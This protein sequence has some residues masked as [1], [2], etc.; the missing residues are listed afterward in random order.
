MKICPKCGLRYP[1]ESVFCFIDGATIESLGDET[2]GSTVAGL[3]RI[4]QAIGSSGWATVYRARHRLTTEP[5]IV[6]LL[7]GQVGPAMRQELAAAAAAARRF[8]HPGV[9]LL[10]SGG[11]ADGGRAYFARTCF[12]GAPLSE[13]LAR[14]VGTVEQVLGIGAQ[15]LGALAH[16]HDFGGSHGD[17][18]PSNVLLGQGGRILLVDVG[19]G[20]ARHRDPW[21]EAGEALFAQRYLA[22]EVSL[23]Q[24]SSASADLY[25]CGVVLF[26]LLAR[27]P[28]VEADN[29]R[30]LRDKQ[31]HWDP[32]QLSGMLPELP[33]PLAACLGRLLD[34][35]P[36]GRPPSAHHALEEL[37]GA[38][39]EQGL[40]LP[41]LPAD[42]PAEPPLR[43]PKLDGTFARWE[44]YRAVFAR[45]LALAF[46]SGPPPQAREAMERIDGKLAA[47]Q[48]VGKKALYYYGTLGDAFVRA[49]QGRASLGGQMAELNAQAKAVRAELQPLKVA[50][51]KHAAA[52]AAFPPQLVEAHRDL[53]GWEGRSGFCEPYREL[54]DAYRR[55][56]ELVDKWYAVRAAQLACDAEAAEKDRALAELDAQVAE[57]REAL[58]VHESNL[59]AELQEV[60]RALGQCGREADA[61]EP[62]LL[63]L[64]TRFCAPLRARPELGAVFRELERRG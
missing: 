57:L 10:L 3:Y 49:A 36:S 4:E 18:R 54:G 12:E 23:Q 52:A 28:F 46:A 53:V 61:I 20:R 47:L 34:P 22:P 21:E 48:E 37:L 17:L 38:A 45:M 50:G 32:Q 13:R 7:A 31:R 60:E 14:G 11:V 62:E 55:M 56:G 43:D 63:D 42:A 29:V 25:G 19:L 35:Y 24:R 33:G 58:R 44:G 41:P 51:E 16:V 1:D 30:Q 59:G 2:I 6:K 39:A 64:A 27:R 15:L 8:S 9:A 40:S 5:C 26:E